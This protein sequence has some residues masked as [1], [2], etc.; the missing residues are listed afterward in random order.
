MY[1]SSPSSTLPLVIP[2]YILIVLFSILKIFDMLY[3]STFDILCN[4][5]NYGVFIYNYGVFIYNYGVVNVNGLLGI[6]RRKVRGFFCM[7]F[8][9]PTCKFG[10]ERFSQWETC[11]SE[12]DRDHWTQT[13]GNCHFPFP[14]SQFLKHRKHHTCLHSHIIN[15][16]LI[17]VDFILQ[18]SFARYMYISGFQDSIY[19]LP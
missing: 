5:Y 11:N 1:K 17:Y 15:S 12:W 13:I 16:T 14:I 19:K 18:N 8:D 9:F 4:I 3:T 2:E 7:C 6:L 10:N